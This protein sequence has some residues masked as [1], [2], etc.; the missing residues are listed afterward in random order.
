MWSVGTVTLSEGLV[1][2]AFGPK[3]SKTDSQ[4]DRFCLEK[5]SLVAHRQIFQKVSDTSSY[6]VLHPGVYG[7]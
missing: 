5:M 7:F 1:F 4:I 3:K 2:Y 6:I